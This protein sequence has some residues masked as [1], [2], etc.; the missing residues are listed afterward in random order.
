[1]AAD[2]GSGH[3]AHGFVY[4]I[5]DE[6]QHASSVGMHANPVTYHVKGCASAPRCGL[7]RE[8]IKSNAHTEEF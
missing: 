1:M 2:A 5:C 3:A 4:C 7:L 6:P 8:L